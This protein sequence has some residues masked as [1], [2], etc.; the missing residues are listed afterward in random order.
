M[1]VLTLMVSLSLLGA[2]SLEARA[3]DYSARKPIH[4]FC[5]PGYCPCGY[6]CRR[7][8]FPCN[9]G[10]RMRPGDRPGL[11]RKRRAAFEQQQDAELACPDI[12]GGT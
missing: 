7:C 12:S 9:A 1:R 4:P 8:D 10:D 11:S 5:E 3:A 6:F 2:I